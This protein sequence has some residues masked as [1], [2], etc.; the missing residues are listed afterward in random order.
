MI[1]E[2]AYGIFLFF[3]SHRYYYVNLN[4]GSPPKQYDLDIDTGSDITWVQCD[5]PCT[6]CT[7]V[8][9]PVDYE[10]QFSHWSNNFLTQCFSVF[11]GSPVIAFIN[12]TT[13][14][15]IVVTLHVLPCTRPETPIARTR[16]SNATMRSH[17][18]I[19]VLLLV[20]W[21]RTTFPLSLPMALSLVPVWPLGGYLFL[22]IKMD[23]IWNFN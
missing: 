7:K 2:K 6:G 13:T 23:N 15:S 22:F 10:N 21:S 14:L 12:R 5:A 16:K 1:I 4:I 19:R 8:N 11:L 20:C 9:F 17:M 18:P 3:Q